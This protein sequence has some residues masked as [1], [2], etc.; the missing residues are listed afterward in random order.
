MFWINMLNL[1][2]LKSE[3]VTLGNQSS[4]KFT[5]TLSAQSQAASPFQPEATPTFPS[6][7]ALCPPKTIPT[8]SIE[9]D[10][11]MTSK[12]QTSFLESCMDSQ[13]PSQQDPVL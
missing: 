10:V 5:P 3:A 6:Q 7:A 12:S 4:L 13:S 8:P 1:T 9:V 11:A 2:E